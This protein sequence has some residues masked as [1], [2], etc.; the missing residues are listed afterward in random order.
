MLTSVSRA[1]ARD[2][3]TPNCSQAA[4]ARGAVRRRRDVTSAAIGTRSSPKRIAGRRSRL[5]REYRDAGREHRDDD[6]S[7]PMPILLRPRR[8]A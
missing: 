2:R 1:R 3:K 6:V 4:T 7:D 5:Q 8:A